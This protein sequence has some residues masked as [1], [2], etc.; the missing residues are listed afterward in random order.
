VHEF[1]LEDVVGP[2]EIFKRTR[3]T[4]DGTMLHPR[5]SADVR[6]G[7]LLEG[8]R[9]TIDGTKLHPRASA[10]VR[11]GELLEGWRITLDGTKLHPR[12][13]ADVRRGGLLEGRQAPLPSSGPCAP[14]RA[15]ADS[16]FLLPLGLGAG[17]ELC[18]S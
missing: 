3:I 1:V 14:H 16:H 10:D 5:A 7:E 6:R 15:N 9:I 17:D 2:T 13:S 4:E 11:R 18:V 12:A 8:W